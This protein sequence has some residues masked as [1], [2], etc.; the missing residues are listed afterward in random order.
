MKHPERAYAAVDLECIR[1]NIR[2]VGAHISSGTRIM[3]VIKADGYGHG[4][5]PIARALAEEEKI[6][7]Y[8]VAT[9]D[10][11]LEITALGIGKPVLILGYCFPVSYE[12]AIREGIRIALFDEESAAVLSENAIRMGKKAF[13]H[14]KVD[15]GMGRIGIRPDE[16]GLA[17]VKRVSQLPGIEIEGIFTHF[18]R[19]DEADKTNALEQLKRYKTFTDAVKEAGVHIPCRH[20]ANSAA[21]LE[22]EDTDYEIVRSGIITYG[23]APSSEVSFSGL[24][25]KPA[26]SIRS[27]VIYVKDVPE[28]MPISYGGTYVTPSKRRIA[29]VSIG[30]ADGYPRSL[31]GKG[32]VL[33]RGQRAKVVGRVCMDQMM[34]DVTDIPGVCTGDM[35]TIVGRDGKECITMEEFAEE[36]GRINYEAVCDIGKRVPRVYPS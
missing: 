23:M 34:V 17:F 14:I 10:E 12:D 11:A 22:M 4:A 13:V 27:C 6:W 16:E 15:T 1:H 36:S 2:E 31:S 28:G 33:I 32:T 24:D 18:A 3:A 29:T 9:M 5:I 26:L 25:L 7:G 19:A 20:C 30:Y 21:I 35:V 8:A